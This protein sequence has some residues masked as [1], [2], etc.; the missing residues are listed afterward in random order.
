MRTNNFNSKQ[1]NGIKIRTGR[2]T[3]PPRHA[4]CHKT[5]RRRRP[6]ERCDMTKIKESKLVVFQIIIANAMP[7]LILN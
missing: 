2:V 1:T 4:H 6:L 7:I 5:M 3:H